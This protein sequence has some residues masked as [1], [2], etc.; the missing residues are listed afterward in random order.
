MT[1]FNFLK[2]KSAY[3]KKISDY[4]ILFVYIFKKKCKIVC[5]I[6]LNIF[7]YTQVFINN[8]LR[9]ESAT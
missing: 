3:R 5:L 1:P 4:F 8:Q 9:N 7:I 6:F 2:T